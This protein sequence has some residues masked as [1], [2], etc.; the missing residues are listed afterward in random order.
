MIA[1]VC[2]HLHPSSWPA[3]LGLCALR[4][5]MKKTSVL[6]P[7]PPP[8]LPPSPSPSC[9]LINR[10]TQAIR[11]RRRW[12][13]TLFVVRIRI[14]CV[15]GLWTRR[16]RCMFAGRSPAAHRPLLSAHAPSGQQ[17][18][19][20][21]PRNLQAC[22]WVRLFSGGV[23][24]LCLSLSPS[25]SL[26]PPPP[27]LSLHPLSVL[28]TQKPKEARSRV[29]PLSGMTFCTVPRFRLRPLVGESFARPLTRCQPGCDVKS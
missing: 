23:S 15:L 11:I 25:L 6:T 16:H 13:S 7:P 3:G 19:A 22:A 4:M 20:H 1:C 18:G 26:L 14:P 29:S 28:L 5:C 21:G 24:R 17:G 12:H 10:D 9:I 2:R 27:S 8:P